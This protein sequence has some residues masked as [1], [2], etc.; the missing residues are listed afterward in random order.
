MVPPIASSP[1]DAPAFRMAMTRTAP[2]PPP[3]AADPAWVIS[4]RGQR[5]F[6]YF[7]GAFD[8]GL[9]TFT[10]AIFDGDVNPLGKLGSILTLTPS[11][12]TDYIQFQLY[13]DPE[14]DGAYLTA[15]LRSTA[16]GAAA[17]PDDGWCT[18]NPDYDPSDTIQHRPVPR[19]GQDT[20]DPVAEGDDGYD[21]YHLVAQWQPACTDG[22]G[23]PAYCLENEQNSFKIVAEGLP[24]LLPGST[25]GFV[26]YG[27]PEPSGFPP[28][29][30]T[31]FD[32]EILFK[33][34]VPAP[35]NAVVL[36]RRR[37]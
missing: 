25:I 37:P 17:M 4:A 13:T 32:G 12:Q 7:F 3:F 21:Y 6:A 33:F 35:V 5:V 18:L 14:Q 8:P 29:P 23:D 19:R 24:Y 15:R 28:F 11:P 31:K 2:L 26:G 20:A 27:K 16:G 1:E 36:L 9:P 22:A 10:L 30:H 34:D